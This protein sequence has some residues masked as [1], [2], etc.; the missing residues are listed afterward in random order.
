MLMADQGPK[1]WSAAAPRDGFAYGDSREP[2]NNPCSACSVPAR[3]WALP[4]ADDIQG[5]GLMSVTAE[6]EIS[7][8]Q[9]VA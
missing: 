3:G 8:V 4:S 1:S 2:A 6:A 7:G 5:H 9:G